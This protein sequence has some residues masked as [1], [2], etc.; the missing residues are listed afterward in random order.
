[1]QIPSF[2]N[3]LAG[4][5][6]AAAIL[7]AT[8]AIGQAQQGHSPQPGATPSTA[9]TP[10]AGSAW[11]IV[12]V[13]P[14]EL[15]GIQV[16]LSPDGQWI[17]GPGPDR[18]FCVWNVSTLDQVCDETPLPIYASSI[19]WAPDSSAVAFS[20]DVFRLMEESDIYVFELEAG[21]S[22][23]LTPDDVEGRL[24]D[25]TDAAVPVDV[26]PAWSA[27]SHSLTFARTAWGGEQRTTEL[28]TIDR[29]G[30][31][32]EFR[33]TVSKDLPLAIFT[34]MYSL[35]DG[36]VL[37]A[38]LPPA[39]D[40]PDTGWWLLTAAGDAEQVLSGSVIEEYPMPAI[41]DVVEHDGGIL[42]SGFSIAALGQFSLETPIA[43]TLDL[44]S[45]DVTALEFPGEPPMTPGPAAISP[46]GTTTIAVLLGAGDA[47]TI[48]I[49][50]G[51]RETVTLGPRRESAVGNEVVHR[52]P[53]WA[54]NDTVFIPGGL[55]SVP[56][57][58]TMES[59]GQATPVA[60]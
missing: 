27:D 16:A 38:A 37:Y 6:L 48:V 25:A 57:L 14:L 11:E 55:S 20:L 47:D 50:A 13:Q 10:G 31:E 40:H 51:E 18:Q 42:V 36:S 17:A 28:M 41:A 35:S 49:T 52:G 59:A 7:L 54:A 32:P 12:D 43:F 1:M 29:G 46:D 24:I 8:H 45:R 15:D 53:D 39:L 26:M 44:E 9:A 58:L 22:E 2:P 60:T 19:T 5:V 4:L 23:N 30:G 56:Y 33:H 3:R 21:R 34:P